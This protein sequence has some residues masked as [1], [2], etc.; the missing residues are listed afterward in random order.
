M[1]GT[2]DAADH[3]RLKTVSLEG[4]QALS[5]AIIDRSLGASSIYC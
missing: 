2:K 3:Y 4:P 5:Q 1:G